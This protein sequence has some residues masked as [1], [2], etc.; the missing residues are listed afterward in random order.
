MRNKLN[1]FPLNNV[2]PVYIATYDGNAFLRMNR[3][4]FSNPVL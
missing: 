4:Y 3:V 2:V 1:E